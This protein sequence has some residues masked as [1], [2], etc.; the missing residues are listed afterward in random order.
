M[1]KYNWHI[2]PKYIRLMRNIYNAM[3]RL[4]YFPKQCKCAQV[5]MFL[6]SNKPGS[7]RLSY[8]PIGL[9]VTF[10]KVFQRILLRRMSVVLDELDIIPERQ[11]GFRRRH[12]TVEQCHRITHVIVN[13]IKCKKYC[14]G[15]FL[16]IKQAFDKVWHAGL[17]YKITWQTDLCVLALTYTKFCSDSNIC[18]RHCNHSYEHWQVASNLLQEELDIVEAWLTKWRIL[19]NTQKLKG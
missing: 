4:E 13:A 17:L 11:F 9:L 16:H 2:P 8:R 10:S 12:G 3:L 14:T 6:K 1:R 5:I 15:V 19:V 7:C 18:W